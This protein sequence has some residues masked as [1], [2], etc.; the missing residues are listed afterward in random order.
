MRGME[1]FK[2]TRKKVTPFA[3]ISGI[4]GVPTTIRFNVEAT[5]IINEKGG[6]DIEV[7][8]NKPSPYFWFSLWYEEGVIG[9]KIEELDPTVPR[10]HAEAAAKRAGWKNGNVYQ[11]GITCRD[12]LT[13]Y[14]FQIGQ[15]F[16][17]REGDEK[18]VDFLLS[19]WQTD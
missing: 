13:K 18:G 3:T 15:R 2:P 19:P 16:S 1:Q 11:N 12:Y 6:C 9:L 5:R 7:D 4:D 8:G 10:N 17:F 14:G